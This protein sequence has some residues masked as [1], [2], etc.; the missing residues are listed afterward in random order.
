MTKLFKIGC[1]LNLL[2]FAAATVADDFADGELVGKIFWVKPAKEIYRRLEFYRE[3]KIESPSF[4]PT[5][6]DA[7][8]LLMFRVAG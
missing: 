1:L 5:G 6:K 8:E 2:F 4:F 3:P 7:F